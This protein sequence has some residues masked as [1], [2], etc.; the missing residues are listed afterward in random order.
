[1]K[2]IEPKIRPK[3]IVNGKIGENIATKFLER[4][5]YTI[6]DRNYLRKWGELDIVAL[7]DNVVSFVEVKTISNPLY[8]AEENMHTWKLKRLRRAV[9]TY[10]LENG[11]LE[12]YDWQFDLI[13]VLLDF[14][15]R[16]GKVK[17]LKDI[18]I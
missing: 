2:H 11:H 14:N 9:Q 4:K 5:C 15:K 7:K 17:H 18:I 12:K 6:L 13:T 8:R 16:V 3:N 1:M 10:L